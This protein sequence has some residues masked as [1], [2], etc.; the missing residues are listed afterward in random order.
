P[1]PTEPGHARWPLF[2]AA[3]GAVILGAGAAC[4]AIASS[5]QSDID[6]APSATAPELEHLASLESS[7]KTYATAGNV[8]V[9]GGAVVAIAGGVLWWRSSGDAAVT[10]TPAVGADHAAVFV[11]GRW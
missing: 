4:W 11:G 10:V 8:L 1:G 2:V 5:K 3:G 6:G 7:A 9:I